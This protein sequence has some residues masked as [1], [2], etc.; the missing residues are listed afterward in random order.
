MSRAD[1]RTFE[2]MGD[3]CLERLDFAGLLRSIGDGP[4]VGASPVVRA[5]PQAEASHSDPVPWDRRSLTVAGSNRDPGSQDAIGLLT[6]PVTRHRSRL[7][8]PA[9]QV[10]I[11][12]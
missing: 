10:D 5:L 12:A 2:M 3:G 9:E 1:R 4:S 6:R 7:A 11:R 8:G